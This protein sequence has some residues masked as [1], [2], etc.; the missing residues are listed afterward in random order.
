[1]ASFWRLAGLCDDLCKLGC[2][3]G[4]CLVNAGRVSQLHGTTRFLKTVF[5][6]DVW[7]RASVKPLALPMREG[8]LKALRDHLRRMTLEETVEDKFVSEWSRDAWIY[9]AVTS[10]N[11]LYGDSSPLRPGGWSKA[12]RRVAKAIGLAVDRLLSHGRDRHPLEPGLEKELRG[13]RLNYAGE[14]I[15]TCQK[16]TLAQVVPALPPAIHGGAINAVDFLSPHSRDLMLNP[17]KSLLVDDGRVLPRLKGIIHAEAGEMDGIAD[18]LVKRGI[19]D[20]IPLDTVAEAAW[21]Q[22]GVVS[23]A[24]KRRSGVPII[25][26][27]GAYVEGEVHYLGG[28]PE[29]FLKLAHATCWLLEQPLL[30][31]R[32]VQVIAGRWV[33][34]MQFRRPSMSILEKTWEY[35]GKKQ[36]KQGIHAEVR[37]ELFQCLLTIPLLHTHLGAEISPVI[38]ASDASTSGGAVGVAH[39]ATDVGVANGQAALLNHNLGRPAPIMVISLFGGIGGSFRTYDILGLQPTALIHFDIHKP[40]NRI[41]SR[42][43]PNAEIHEDVKSFTR[44]LFREM[45]ARYV[46]IEEIHIWAGFPCTDLSA[47]RAFGK[48]LAG[49]ASSLFFEVKRIRKV[50]TEEAGSHITVKM[51]VENVASMKREECITARLW[52]VTP[53][54]EVGLGKAASTRIKA[55]S[56]G[57]FPDL[58][59]TFSEPRLLQGRYLPGDTAKWG[60]CEL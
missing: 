10:C 16:L 42:R 57:Y 41:V 32:L 19:C 22:A 33:H 59:M 36:Y 25:H 45:L 38:T 24:K 43:W 29:R 60:A 3:L 40:G 55:G 18:E 8:G 54:T 44:E 21:E 58:A 53:V 27:L 56:Y 15:G 50:V 47:A 13:K 23:S 20:W 48:G 49:P 31:K 7:Q 11:S 4:W 14:E 9:A 51:V 17:N 12:E 46:D 37:R 35:V 26:E 2:A 52:D 6:S 34:V 28:S 5:T 39:T 1:M 30:S